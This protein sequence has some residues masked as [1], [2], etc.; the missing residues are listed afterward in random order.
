MIELARRS[1]QVDSSKIGKYWRRELHSPSN[2]RR[3]YTARAFTRLEEIQIGKWESSS[4]PRECSRNGRSKLASGGLGSFSFLWTYISIKAF[5]SY[6][7][8]LEIVYVSST[9][10]GP[11][12]SHNRYLQR[13]A[14]HDIQE[15]R[16]IQIATMYTRKMPLSGGVYCPRAKA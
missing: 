8:V 11:P 7:I 16:D 2:W 13:R 15:P 9:S 14:R 5:L 3:G 12:S 4:E 1:V 10:I 6:L